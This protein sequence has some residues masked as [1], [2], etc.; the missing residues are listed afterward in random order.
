[1]STYPFPAALAYRSG[2][3]RCSSPRRTSS[4]AP[5]ASGSTT[6]SCRLRPRVRVTRRVVRLRWASG[7]PKRPGARTEAKKNTVCQ[8]RVRRRAKHMPSAA[9]HLADDIAPSAPPRVED[10]SGRCT[11]ATRLPRACGVAVAASIAARAPPS[12]AA[13][14]STLVAWGP[15]AGEQRFQPRVV[16]D[17]S[18]ASTVAPLHLCPPRPSKPL[19]RRR[20]ASL[21]GGALRARAA[22]LGAGGAAAGDEGPALPLDPTRMPSM[23][24]PRRSSAHRSAKKCT[25]MS[26]L[27]CGAFDPLSSPRG[28]PAGTPRTPKSARARPRAK[29]RGPPPGAAPA[30]ARGDPPPPPRGIKYPPCGA[31]GPKAYRDL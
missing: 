5:R 28:T 31:A 13:A 7:D 14:Y 18:T 11:R 23:P 6:P 10:D 27:C 1:M 29:R 15:A 16:M 20:L 4:R 22:L 8:T 3:R 2:A 9:A 19:A 24:N 17:T 25:A 30:A 26:T 21:R 12:R